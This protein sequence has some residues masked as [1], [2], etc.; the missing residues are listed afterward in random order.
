[1]QQWGVHS[2]GG[3][4]QQ[5]AEVQLSTRML[6]SKWILSLFFLTTLQSEG[7]NVLLHFSLLLSPNFMDAGGVGRRLQVLCFSS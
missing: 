3:E 5:R 7:K 2:D 6:Q 4:K 1:M